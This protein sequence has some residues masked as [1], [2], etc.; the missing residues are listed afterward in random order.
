MIYKPTAIA[1]SI[2]QLSGKENI[3]IEGDPP[4]MPGDQTIS[5]NNQ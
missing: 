1:V 5:N 4:G 3:E 2:R